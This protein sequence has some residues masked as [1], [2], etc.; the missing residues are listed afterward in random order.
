MDT[1]HLA[2]AGSLHLSDEELARF[3]DGEIAEQDARHIEACEQCGG[4]LRDMQASYAAYRLIELPSTAIGRR[5]HASLRR[6]V[7]V[8]AG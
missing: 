1:K 4:R 5:F 2:G 3:E 8:P 7:R 6:N